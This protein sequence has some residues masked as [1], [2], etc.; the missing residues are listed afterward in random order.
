MIE[1][2]NENKIETTNENKIETCAC[3]AESSLSAAPQRGLAEHV[4]SLLRLLWLIGPTAP[5]STIQDTKFE[6]LL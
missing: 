4:Q 5:P 6:Q 1:N 3:L 2:T